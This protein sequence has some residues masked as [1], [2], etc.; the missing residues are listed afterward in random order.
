MLNL[1]KTKHRVRRSVN[2]NNH[3]KYGVRQ[4]LF[5]YGLYKQTNNLNL[6]VFNI[7]W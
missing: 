7:K 5:P 2:P 3:I 6:L 1:N 4:V